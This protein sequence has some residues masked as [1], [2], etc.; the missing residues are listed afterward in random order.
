MKVWDCFLFNHETDM[1][2][3]RLEALDNAVDSFVLVEATHTLSGHPKPSYFLENAARFAKWRDRIV[4]VQADDLMSVPPGWD[5]EAAQREWCRK[6]LT[7][8]APDDIVLLSDVDEIPNVA[9]IERV[10]EG[11]DGYVMFSHY[12]CCFAVDWLFS[13]SPS[14]N[15]TASRYENIRSF[16]E[17]RD[18]RAQF[19]VL[20][21]VGWHFSWVGGPAQ[22]LTK[23]H[24]FPHEQLIPQLTPDLTSERFYREGVYLDGT[25]LIPVDVDATWPAYITSRRCP[26]NWFRPR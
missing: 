4:H 10:R 1:L 15:S 16:R 19:P 8:A 21:G 2:E 23:I 22:T 6:G 3:C 12:L 25:K 24:S 13:T 20:P 9:S 11:I 5:R 17:M 7:S 18:T 14:G 26:P